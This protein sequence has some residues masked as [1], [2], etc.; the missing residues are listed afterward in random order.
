MSVKKHLQSGFLSKFGACGVCAALRMS[1]V[2][3]PAV[4]EGERLLATLRCTVDPDTDRPIEALNSRANPAYVCAALAIRQ[5]HPTAQKGNGEPNYMGAARMYFAADQLNANSGSMV[6][7]WLE[8]LDKLD[9]VSRQATLAT[10]LAE[11]DLNEL[12]PTLSQM[13]DAP[14]NSPP[15]SVLPS[16]PYTE[17]EPSDAAS[18]ASSALPETREERLAQALS[19]LHISSSVQAIRV[20]YSS[21]TNYHDYDVVLRARDDYLKAGKGNLDKV[22]AEFARVLRAEQLRLAMNLAAGPITTSALQQRSVLHDFTSNDDARCTE[23]IHGTSDLDCDQLVT[24]IVVAIGQRQLA[25]DQACRRLF[26]SHEAIQQCHE[27]QFTYQNYLR[28]G[29]VGTASAVG[30]AI[31]AI[32]RERVQLEAQ[33]AREKAFREAWSKLSPKGACLPHKLL[34]HMSVVTFIRDETGALVVENLVELLLAERAGRLS[35]LESAVLA[36]GVVKEAMRQ[37]TSMLPVPTA[38]TEYDIKRAFEGFVDSAEGDVAA[39]AASIA[40]AHLKV[41]FSKVVSQLDR[42]SQFKVNCD[43]VRCAL[44]GVG[45]VAATQAL[46][47]TLLAEAEHRESELMLRL[48]SLGVC[49]Q[50]YS[51]EFGWPPIIHRGG[52]NPPPFCKKTHSEWTRLIVSG[53]G[54]AAQIARS[55]ANAARTAELYALLQA[56]PGAAAFRY[57]SG[58]TRAKKLISKHPLCQAFIEGE[59]LFKTLLAVSEAGHVSI[60]LRTMQAHDLETQ[61]LSERAERLR[62]LT[63]AMLARG[64]A[65]PAVAIDMAVAGTVHAYETKYNEATGFCTN[66]ALE[67]ILEFGGSDKDMQHAADHICLVYRYASLDAAFQDVAAGQ[68]VKLN[69]T[70]ALVVNA[71]FDGACNHLMELEAS[72]FTKLPASLI[73]I[74]AQQT[75]I[76][77]TQLSDFIEGSARSAESAAALAR[78]WHSGVMRR[79]H[80]VHAALLEREAAADLSLRDILRLLDQSLPEYLPGRLYGSYQAPVRYA[81]ALHHIYTHT[82]GQ[83]HAHYHTHTHAV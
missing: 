64:V 38:S 73:R 79:A 41:Q 81:R 76:H 63:D 67:D 16:P 18:T 34:M 55:V 71:R 33:S 48:A 26:V 23:F 30:E 53:A 1:L 70:D 31:S 22:A 9:Q 68:D 52:Y 72:Y 61:L 21:D 78:D 40:D 7:G 54:D 13:I 37:G 51:A 44:L 47:N 62:K 4:E 25:L 82:P 14:Q 36:L 60:H 80:E 77:D 17:T 66:G 69:L 32:V 43:D 42:T 11:L 28:K 74:I 59:T 75:W 49:A 19:K 65:E 27:A 50:Q 57:F 83:P 2:P 20:P 8:K 12:D 15:I 24:S 56:Q 5:S 3:A 39:I 45:D 6:K 10:H 29:E 58:A 46:C 35:A